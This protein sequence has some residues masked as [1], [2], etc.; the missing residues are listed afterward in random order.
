MNTDRL[1]YLVQQA[2]KK[3]ITSG[4]LDELMTLIRSDATGEI[5][6][7][8]NVLFGDVLAAGSLKDYDQAYWQAAFHEVVHPPHTATSVH[9]MR[10]WGWVAAASFLVLLG[11]GVFF[12]LNKKT[13]VKTLAEKP[14]NITPGKAGAV[15]TLGDGSQVV[16]DSLNNGLVAAQ[17]GSQAVLKNGQLV[18]DNTG[19]ANGQVVYNTISTPKGRQFSLVLPDGSEA[20]LNAASSVRYPTA[21]TGW[22]RNVEVTGEVYFEVAKNAEMPFR[23]NVNHRATIDVL[24]TDFNVNA[25]ENEKYVNTTLITGSIRIQ[26][27]NAEQQGNSVLLKPGQRAQVSNSASFSITVTN[28]A[29]AKNAIAWKNGYFN[30]DDLSLEELMRQVERWYDVQVVYEKGVP[31]KSFFGKV[32][33]DLPLLDFMEGLKDWGVRFRL[34]GR[35]L[36]ITGTD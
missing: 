26:A 1:T 23:V 24:G 27:G 25:Y 18:Y 12:M 20:W 6:G 2:R 31:A 13:P 35:K 14:V 32:N 17:N 3:E 10:R 34:D 16:L 8:L 15:L 30:L 36:I 33:R 11:T 5:L 4:E 21:F 28:N 19:Q 9:F 22:E 7:Q 29:D